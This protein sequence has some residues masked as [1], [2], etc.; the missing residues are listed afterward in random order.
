MSIATARALT[1][2][3]AAV[4]GK[5]CGTEEELRVEAY[6][7]PALAARWPPVPR[8]VITP[9]LGRAGLPRQAPAPAL[10]S[11]SLFPFEF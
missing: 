9:T 11:I 5:P 10:T 2:P 7:L 8:L 6:Q 1:S 4:G 3:Q